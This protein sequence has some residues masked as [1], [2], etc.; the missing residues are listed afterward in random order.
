MLYVSMTMIPTKILILFPY[1]I[2]L[3]LSP[4]C[5]NMDVAEAAAMYVYFILSPKENVFAFEF[6]VL[7]T[8]RIFFKTQVFELLLRTENCIFSHRYI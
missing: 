5:L 4:N 2:L 7:S 8:Y 1:K 3:E 6:S